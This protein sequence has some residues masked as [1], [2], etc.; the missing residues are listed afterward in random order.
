MD[1]DNNVEIA[2]VGG[3]VR[4]DSNGKIQLKNKNLSKGSI[5]PSL[6]VGYA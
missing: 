6:S 3:D 4:G 1:M 2:G 5:T